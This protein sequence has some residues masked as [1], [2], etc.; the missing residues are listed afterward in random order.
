M[1]L[2]TESASR[3]CLLSVNSTLTRR[4]LG[5]ANPVEGED[6]EIDQLFAEVDEIFEDQDDDPD[7]DEPFSV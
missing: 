6:G 2:T 4:V 5:L 1:R 3:I 7:Q